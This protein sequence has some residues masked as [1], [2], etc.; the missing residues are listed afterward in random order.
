MHIIQS[1]LFDFEA[2]ITIKNNDRLTMVLEAL[3]AEKLIIA[4][5]REHWTGR[6]GYS[7]RGM[8]SALIAGV[9][10][11]CS[12][13]AEVR[14][15]LG[16]EKDTR[17]V[18]GFARDTIPSDDA[19]S[20]FLKK[21]VNHEDLLEQ[22]FCGLVERLREL[23]PGFGGKVVV[24]STD[25]KA[26]ANGFRKNPADIDARWGVKGATLPRQEL[27]EETTAKGKKKKDLYSW[28]GY[29][30]HL[31]VD[32]LY[33]LPITFIVTPANESDTTQMKPLL[34]KAE[35]DKPG[36]YP[37][38]V[39]ADKGY[40]SKDNCLAIFE[41]CHAAPIIPLIEKPHWES[42]DICNA[43]GTPTCGCGLEMVYWGRDG[44]YLKYRCPEA[45]GKGKCRWR[46]KCSASSYGYVLKLAVMKED[47]RRH[48]PIPRESRKWARLYRLRTSVERV[49][50]RLKELLGLGKITVRGIAKVTVKALLSLLV[51]LAAA[52]GMAERHRLKEVRTLV[53]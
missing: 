46:F 13:I 2:F 25:I 28:F 50:S 53:G 4:L 42:P 39:I 36:L 26:Y 8:W 40:D 29:K 18:C 6:K 24:D 22:C 37:E 34:K 11:Q 44:K 35:L 41:D 47:P 48:L 45:A 30:L 27:G 31:I 20:R 52:V 15:L 14:R 9:L 33:E 1:P 17:I 51:M 43:K 3:S 10:Y 21:L 49:N 16:R 38:A 32:A 23:L 7:V 5:E 12:S 19:F